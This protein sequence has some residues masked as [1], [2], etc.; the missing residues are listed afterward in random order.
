MRL[1]TVPEGIPVRAF[2]VDKFLILVSRAAGET[3]PSLLSKYAARPAT[4]GVA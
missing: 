3:L 4:W 1:L 2:L